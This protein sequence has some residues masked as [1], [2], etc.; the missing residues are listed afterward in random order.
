MAIGAYLGNTQV[1]SAGGSIEYPD[2]STIDDG[3]HVYTTDHE[4]VPLS[5]W[6]ED[7]YEPL[8]IVFKGDDSVYISRFIVITDSSTTALT[9]YGGGISSYADLRAALRTETIKFQGQQYTATLL[10]W[11]LL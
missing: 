7:L 6:A 2:L 4:V 1:W 10:P 11:S 8:Y 3:I 9:E 5:E